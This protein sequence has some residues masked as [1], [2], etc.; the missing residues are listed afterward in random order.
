MT[1]PDSELLN[2]AGIVRLNYAGK[3]IHSPEL[4]SGPYPENYPT[5]QRP[6]ISS[7][8]EAAANSLQFLRLGN[9]R[10]LSTNAGAKHRRLTPRSLR[11]RH[12]PARPAQSHSHARA[13]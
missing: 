3:Q 6:N 7:A 13:P 12:D 10:H 9:Q 4:F 5:I 8:A 11:A 1:P 2:C